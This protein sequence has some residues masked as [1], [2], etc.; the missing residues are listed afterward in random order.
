MR[1]TRGLGSI[2]NR[3]RLIRNLALQAGASFLSLINSFSPEAC[4]RACHGRS[5]QRTNAATGPAG[6]ARW[7]RG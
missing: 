5:Y 3:S 2:K 6:K 7:L 1:I 4:H